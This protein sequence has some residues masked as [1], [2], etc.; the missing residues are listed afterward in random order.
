M[1]YSESAPLRLQ[2]MRVLN[3]GISHS[4]YRTGTTSLLQVGVS[5]SF[6]EALDTVLSAVSIISL[7]PLY[8]AVYL[9]IGVLVD[10][11]C[12]VEAWR[13]QLGLANLTVGREVWL[14]NR[15]VVI[16]VC[17]T[18]VFGG[19][20]FL[21]DLD[22]PVLQNVRGPWLYVWVQGILQT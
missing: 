8:R 16:I 5:A 22:M 10:G 6:P 15:L 20:L 1:L 11:I 14:G 9:F 12:A 19:F 21:L 4:L 13:R 7:M 3:V 2:K 18:S 17:V